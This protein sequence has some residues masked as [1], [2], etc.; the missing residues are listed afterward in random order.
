MKCTSLPDKASMALLKFRTLATGDF[1]EAKLRI[2]VLEE[3][4]RLMQIEKYGAGG[5]KLSQA[6][7]WSCSS[8]RLSSLK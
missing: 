6:R 8:L 7:S 5:E 2:M 4:L 1:K 3:R